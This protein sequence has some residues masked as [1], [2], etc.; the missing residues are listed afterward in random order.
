MGYYIEQT[1]SKFII[2]KEN[3]KE[4]LNA[5]KAVFIP[6]NMDCM[7]YVEGKNIPHFSWVNTQTVLNSD[8]LEDA[9]KEIRYQPKYDNNKNI[10]NVEFTG[11]KYGS[12]KVFFAALAPYV[13]KDSYISFDGEDGDKWTWKFDG[14]KVEHTII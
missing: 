7:D 8:T 3:F 6:E 11:Q 5:L 4:A 1:D 10:V 9:L 14:K 2:K 12:E 13:E